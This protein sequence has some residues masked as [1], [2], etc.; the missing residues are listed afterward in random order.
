MAIDLDHCVLAIKVKLGLHRLVKFV[1]VTH[2]VY[3]KEYTNNGLL[4]HT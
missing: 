1:I 2:C 3:C 4:F